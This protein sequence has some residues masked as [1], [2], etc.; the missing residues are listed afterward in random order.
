MRCALLD[1]DACIEIIRGNP[2]PVSSFPDFTFLVSTIS[3]FEILSGLKGLKNTKAEQRATSF[4]SLA[5]IRL[6][7]EEAARAAARIRIHLEAKGKPIGAYD[8]LIAGHA[9]S[10]K[11]PLITGNHKEFQRIP[12]LSLLNWRDK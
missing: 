8:L 11:F 7:D 12:K 5:E 4:L 2:L 9:Q 6:F 3:Q 1:T 10:L